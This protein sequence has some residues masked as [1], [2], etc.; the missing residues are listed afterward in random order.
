MWSNLTWRS[1]ASA[2]TA[3]FFMMTSLLSLFAPCNFARGPDPAFVVAP[4]G[5]RSKIGLNL[6]MNIR[7]T[8]HSESP[9][10]EPF[11]DTC[12]YARFTLE[13]PVLS[14]NLPAHD[15]GITTTRACR[16]CQNGQNKARIRPVTTVFWQRTVH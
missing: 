10:D 6:K 1:A 9:L 7:F 15:P 5:G 2:A 12:S 14:M 16:S 3:T 13:G 11:P 8:R 4:Y